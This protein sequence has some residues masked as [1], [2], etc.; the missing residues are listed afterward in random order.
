KNPKSAMIRT[1]ETICLAGDPGNKYFN[2]EIKSEFDFFSFFILD[3]P[4]WEKKIS[5]FHPNPFIRPYTRKYLTSRSLTYTDYMS[6]LPEGYELI[7]IVPEELEKMPHKN[8]N[9]VLKWVKN[10]GIY[11][12]FKR[13][14]GGYMIIKDN[15][16][17]SWSV[18]DCWYKDKVAIGIVTDSCHRKRGLAA[19]ASAANAEDLFKRGIFELDWLC[20]DIN[21]GS[22]STSRKIGFSLR[23][24]YTT[25]TAI[26][27]YENE[28]DP[29]RDGWL[30]WA[31]FYEKAC[32][33]ESRYFFHCSECYAKAY[34]V[35]GV[36]RVLSKAREQKID[37]ENQFVNPIFD[38]FSDKGRWRDFVNEK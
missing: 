33:T 29:T 20:I 3:N 31:D 26:A 13:N 36:I 30:D 23:S 32:E 10:Y 38:R 25:Y 17:A 5:E 18:T 21:R 9:I 28:T 24:T 11:D 4:D 12:N 19:I 2:E 14:G 6:K 34:D 1:S 27:P 7:K 8:A 16:I 22:E 37:I 15:D 35:E